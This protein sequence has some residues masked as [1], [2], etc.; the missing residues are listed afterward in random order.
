M[1]KEHMVVS[2][3]VVLLSNLGAH[4]TQRNETMHFVVKAILNGQVSLETAFKNIRFELRRMHILIREKEEE[5]RIRRPRGV[6]F[7]T[8]QLLLDRVTI[9]VMKAIN[10]EWVTVVAM[11]ERINSGEEE[12][13]SGSCNC[14]LVVR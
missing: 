4:S 14:N 13:V 12:V 11:V 7:L 2:C 5:S 3:Y 6:N 9:W 8:F 10:P 1:L